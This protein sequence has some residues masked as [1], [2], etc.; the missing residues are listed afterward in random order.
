MVFYCNNVT[1]KSGLFNTSDMGDYQISASPMFTADDLWQYIRIEMQLRFGTLA[2]MLI[3]WHSASLGNH[4]LIRRTHIQLQLVEKHTTNNWFPKQN[5]L[6]NRYVI[7][8]NQKVML[9]PPPTNSF[10]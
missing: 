3:C 9:S 6:V 2:D 8:V 10:L 5:L 7:S 1:E 4:C